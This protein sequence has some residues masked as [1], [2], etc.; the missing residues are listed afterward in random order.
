M[1]NLNSVILRLSPHSTTGMTAELR[2]LQNGL[3]GNT[4]CQ[5]LYSTPR[6]PLYRNDGQELVSH[7]VR[8]QL[9]RTH[10]VAFSLIQL[11]RPV[12]NAGEVRPVIS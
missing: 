10:K 4:T 5:E 2:S 9:G 1:R 11:G 8:R 7:V 3:S 6:I 12:H